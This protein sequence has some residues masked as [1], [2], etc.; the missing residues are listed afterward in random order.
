MYIVS[1][2]TPNYT[3]KKQTKKRL[4]KMSLVISFNPRTKAISQ[5]LKAPRNFEI[6]KNKE[7]IW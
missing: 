7:Q 2:G 4:C 6:M 1:S 5:T 3:L